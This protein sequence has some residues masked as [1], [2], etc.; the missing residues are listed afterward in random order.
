MFRKLWNDD[1]GVVALEYL[2]LCTVVG[3]GMAV[4]FS[5][6]S[7]ALN[8]EYCELASAINA[9]DQ[10][11]EINVSASDT[12]NA[13]EGNGA[14]VAGWKAGTSVRD[15]VGSWDYERRSNVA[16]SDPIPLGTVT[17]INANP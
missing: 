5:A 17:T 8:S 13:S 10:G 3:L 7:D 6:V 16:D 12:D 15:T 11:Y 14:T 1:A 4:G 2:F 9:L